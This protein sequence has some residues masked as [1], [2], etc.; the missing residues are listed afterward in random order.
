MRRYGRSPRAV[1]ALKS[2][3]HV[4]ALPVS[5]RA[6]VSFTGMLLRRLSGALHVVSV[7]SQTPAQLSGNA[8]RDG[9]WPRVPCALT[10][11]DKAT[12]TATIIAPTDVGMRYS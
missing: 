7:P 9:A 8:V 2:V 12:R 5:S 11:D 6:I 1:S 3:R 4:Y 10:G